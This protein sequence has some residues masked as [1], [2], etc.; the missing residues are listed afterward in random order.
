MTG[1]TDELLVRQLIDGCLKNRLEDQQKLYK[2]FYSYTMS[3]C[4][5]Y[6]GNK[7]EAADILNDGFMKAFTHLSKFDG[8]KPFHLWLRR[9]MMNTA[10]DYY[11][12][13][14]KYRK[15]Y[16]LEEANNVGEDDTVQSKLNYE[17]L[18]RLVQELPP[19]YRTVFNLFAIDGYSHEEI[20]TMLNISVGASKSNLFKARQKLQQALKTN[21]SKSPENQHLKVVSLRNSDPD[22]ARY[23]TRNYE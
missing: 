6:A 2:H 7:F 22:P 23:K 21:K 15:T 11:R 18:L 13:N 20:A 19:S 10:I 5:R 9:I 4:L 1:S 17:D 3:I 16:D 14:L 8:R 12:S